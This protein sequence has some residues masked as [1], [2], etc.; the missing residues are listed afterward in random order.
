MNALAVILS[1]SLL[2]TGATIEMIAGEGTCVSGDCENGQ[3][4]VVWPG[5]HRYTGGFKFGMKHGRGV[6]TWKNGSRYEGGWEGGNMHGR[7]DDFI[8]GGDL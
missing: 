1:L 5:G 4:T 3:G 2:G 6:Y 7:G 8:A